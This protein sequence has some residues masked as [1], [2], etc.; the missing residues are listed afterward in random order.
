[1]NEFPVNIIKISSA[2]IKKLPNNNKAYNT[3][4]SICANATL[5]NQRVIAKSVDDENMVNLLNELGVDFVQGN[6]SAYPEEL[7]F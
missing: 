7:C 1:M 5:A 6:Y 2:L 4:T 3:V